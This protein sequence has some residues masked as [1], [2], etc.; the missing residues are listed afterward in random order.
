MFYPKNCIVY[1]YT[2]IKYNN[3]KI[4]TNSLNILWITVKIIEHISINGYIGIRR[5]LWNIGIWRNE[6]LSIPIGPPIRTECFVTEL[7]VTPETK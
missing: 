1:A 3:V 7:H 2:L 5:R 6:H 4:Y